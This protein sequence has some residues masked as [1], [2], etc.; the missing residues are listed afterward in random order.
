ML[1]RACVVVDGVG[2]WVVGSGEVWLGVGGV[3]CGNG[4]RGGESRRPG[5]GWVSSALESR[6]EGKPGSC[7]SVDQ[8]V[9]GSK[10]DG[11]SYPWNGSRG[12]S[13]EARAGGRGC[14]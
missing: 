14:G 11:P 7:G 9:S 8:A 3:S 6:E 12:S 5:G 10:A 2:D 1:A 4:E 13:G